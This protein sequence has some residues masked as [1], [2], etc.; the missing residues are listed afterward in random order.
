MT[1]LLTGGAGYIG[2]HIVRAFRAAGTGVVVLDNLST[3]YRDFVPSDVPFIEGSVTD[4]VA[5][6][7][8]LDDYGV[9]GVLHLAG[10]KYA[11]VPVQEPL[12]FYRENVLGMQV[13]LEAVVARG[14]DRV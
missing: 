12:R 11:G 1:W 10:L 6:A 14:I 2:A 7:A 8:A 5:V 3:G 13:M 9:T 4:P